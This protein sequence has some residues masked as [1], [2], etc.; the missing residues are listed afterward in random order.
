[1]AEVYVLE[2]PG[3]ARGPRER[4]FWMPERI[5]DERET[6]PGETLRDL[7]ENAGNVFF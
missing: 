7:N 1:M 2:T 6:S 5:S 4:R 3:L